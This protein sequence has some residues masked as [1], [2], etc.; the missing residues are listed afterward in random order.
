M[1]DEESEANSDGSQVSSLMLDCGQHD[2]GKCQL[3][4]GEHFDEEPP[5]DGTVSSESDIDRHRSRE[6]R[7]YCCGRGNASYHL[8]HEYDT[9]TNCWNGAGKAECERNLMTY[10]LLW[11]Y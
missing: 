9:A 5:R 4:C 8:R 2:D 10:Q 6:E 11:P 1:S 7:R 3:C